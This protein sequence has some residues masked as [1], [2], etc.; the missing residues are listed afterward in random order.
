MVLH[1]TLLILI[2]NNNVLSQLSLVSISLS[3]AEEEK[4]ML[5]TDLQNLS[6]SKEMMI[7][8][9]WNKR[10]K[11]NNMSKIKDKINLNFRDEAADVKNGAEVELAKNRKMMQVSYGGNL[12]SD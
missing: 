6:L 3:A 12:F 5:K 11:T 2:L 4:E 1:W 7:K 10:W 8:S 9:A